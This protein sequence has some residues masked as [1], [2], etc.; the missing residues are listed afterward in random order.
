[1]LGDDAARSPARPRDFEALVRQARQAGLEADL[2]VEG[3]QRP[4]VGS[5][6]EVAAYRIVEESLTNVVKHAAGA[7]AHVRLRFG[8]DAVTVRVENDAAP[9]AGDLASVGAGH[10]LLGMQERVAIFGGRIDAGPRP[11][12]GFVIEAVMPLEEAAV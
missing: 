12:G 3:V 7:R 6:L 2:E 11:G 5:S 9:G 8:A 1:M 4:A 10:G